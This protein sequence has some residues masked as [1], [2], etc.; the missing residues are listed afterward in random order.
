MPLK[1]DDRWRIPAAAPMPLVVP[2]AAV[3][4]AAAAV[5]SRHHGRHSTRALP[6]PGFRCGGRLSF[7]LFYFSFLAV[8]ASPPADAVVVARGYAAGFGAAPHH[9]PY[10]HSHNGHHRHHHH[11]HGRRSLQ[12]GEMPPPPPDNS[13]APLVHRCGTEDLNAIQVEAFEEQAQRRA[14]CAGCCYPRNDCEC[15]FSPQTRRCAPLPPLPAALALASQ[16]ISP[17]KCPWFSTSCTTLPGAGGS[18]R[19]L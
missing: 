10:G 3:G 13:T 9:H 7:F 19:R 2:S 15:I 8:F 18:L 14:A 4:G 1:P 5:A 16:R 17:W 11:P 6:R 12:Q